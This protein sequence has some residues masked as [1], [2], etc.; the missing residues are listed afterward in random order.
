MASEET[1]YRTCDACRGVGTVKVVTGWGG[2]EDAT[3]PGC[4]G[5]GVVILGTA[6]G[7]ADKLADMA[8]VL[9]DIMDKCTDIKEIV[10]EL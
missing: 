4:D 5:S 7:L 9:N 1:I 6:Q 8:D 10:D 3:C 2:T